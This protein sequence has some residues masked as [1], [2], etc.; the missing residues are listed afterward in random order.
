MSI[1]REPPRTLRPLASS[2]ATSGLERRARIDLGCDIAIAALGHFGCERPAQAVAEI[3]LVDGA[4]GKLMR[5]FQRRGGVRGPGA[6]AQDG[7]RGKRCC[8]DVAACEH[9]SPLKLF[10]ID[11][12]L[13]RRCAHVSR[14]RA[15]VS[16]V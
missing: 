14:Y 16:L 7:G 10:L 5:D 6:E 12:V 2:G 4:A 8:D 9:V 1:S 3:A 13:G 15:E 11:R